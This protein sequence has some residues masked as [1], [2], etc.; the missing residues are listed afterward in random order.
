MCELICVT[1]RKIF[2]DTFG[3]TASFAGRVREIL[4]EGIRVILREKDLSEDEYYRLLCEVGDRRVTAHSF[5]DAARR[6]GCTSLH[7]PLNALS[8]S[9]VSEFETVGCSVHS[10]EQAALADKYGATYLT[11]G[12]IFVTDCKKGLAP[13]G[14]ELIKDILCVTSLPVYAIGGITPQNAG[15]TAEAGAAGVCVM[16]GFMKCADPAE[17]ADKFRTVFR[18]NGQKSN[19]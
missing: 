7:M 19:I 16:S 4:S 11:A 5:P 18:N 12:H 10:A 13:R 17:L 6:F 9:D 2:Y 1:N 15:M 14:T 3:I 8:S